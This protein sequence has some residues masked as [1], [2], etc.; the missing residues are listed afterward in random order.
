M[1]C[2]DIGLWRAFIDGEAPAERELASHLVECAS[3]RAQVDVLR[4]SAAR[5]AAAIGLL[6]PGTVPSP[7][8]VA[9]ARARLAPDAAGAA[10]TIGRTPTAAAGPRRLGVAPVRRLAAVGGI[11]AALALGAVLATP[12]GQIAAARFLTQFR[13]ERFA[14]ISIDPN[15][16]R[17]PLSRFDQLGDVR[18]L[19]RDGRGP[20]E[21]EVVVSTLA[22]ASQR[23][24]FPLKQVDPA[25]L[26]AELR[27]TP[28]I[29]V[30]LGGEYRFTF[31]SAKAR[32][33]LDQIGHPEAQIP[34]KYEGATLVVNVPTAAILQYDPGNGR[35]SSLMVGQADQITAGVEGNV[36]LDELRDFLLGLPGLPADTVS[37]LRAVGDWRTTLPVP[38][39]VDKVAWQPTT[40][41]GAQGVMLSDRGGLGSGVL[42]QRDGHILGVAGTVPQVD[43]LR[44][45]NGMR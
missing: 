9:M 5:S 17:N 15:Q 36:T 1:T 40:V 11:A 29:R 16:I 41:G 42:W 32:R 19:T 12:T 18:D 21:R 30:V 25:T 23:A 6:A 4:G 10:A 24:G 22:E 14:V 27:V 28:R 45:A 26:P 38:V 2:P 35:G 37:Q 31:Q 13:S 44:V 3:C 43:V 33:Y 20:R 34:A 7:A 39:P 8:A